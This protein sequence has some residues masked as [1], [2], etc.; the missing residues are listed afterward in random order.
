MVIEVVDGVV[1]C[2]STDDYDR[3]ISDA[4]TQAEAFYR[5]ELEESKAG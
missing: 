4:V 2:V 1:T 5:Q 3:C